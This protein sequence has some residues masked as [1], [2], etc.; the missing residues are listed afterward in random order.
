M[1]PMVSPV[2]VVTL[3]QTDLEKIEVL[4]RSTNNWSTWS[5]KIQ[6]Y[7]LLKHGGGY[8]LGLIQRPDPLID[9]IGAGTWDL[10]NLC[11]IAALRTR[12]TPEEGEFLRSFTN[13]HLAWTELKGR[14]EKVGPI[15][16]ILLIQQALSTRFRRGECLSVTSTMLTELVR[17]IYAISLPK[18]EDFLMIML[19]NAMTD[20]FPHVRN[21]IADAITT[22]SPSAPY[23]PSNIRAR[24]DVE[25][26]LI[27]SD[28]SKS[29]DVAMVANNK[30]GHTR[31]SKT[32]SDCGHT[33]HSS[34]CTTCHG[35]GHNAKDCFGKGGAMEG[36][37]D[38]VL[39]RKRAAR[40]ATT[41]GG[42]SSKMPKPAS[43]GKPGGLRYDTSGRAYLLDSET[44][45]AVYVASTGSTTAA[46]ASETTQ[47]FAG[48]ASDA[49][50]PSFIRELSS[51]HDDEFTALLAAFDDIQ[52]SLDW[53]Q[54]SRSVDFAGLTYKAPN[55][56]QRTIVDP[57]IVP[58][59]LD[60]GASVHI[61]NTEGDFF[62]L[63]P[64]S[65]RTVNGV[66]SSSMQAMG[67]GTLRLVVAKGIH[68]TLDN[69][70]FIPTATVRLISV[71]S[72]CAAHRCVASFDAT[73]CWVQASSGTRMLSGTLTSRHLYALSGG[74]LSAEHA[75]LMQRLPTLQS[76]HRRL[77]HANYRS[78]YDLARSGNATG[79][80][81]NLS[82]EPPICDDCILGKQT[83]TSVPKVCVGDKATRKLGIVHVDLM[84]HP[85]TVSAAGNKYIMDIIDDFSSY[86]WAL[87]LTSKAEAPLALQAWERAREL[88]VGTK[89]GIY[90]SDNGELKS[91]AMHE[92][93]LSRGTQHQFTAPY[94]SAQNGRVE[95]LHRTLM[96][97]ARAM[98]SA[99]NAPVNRWDEFVLTACYLTN[100]TPVASQA[101]H[102]PYE[103]WFG[104]KPNL[105]H[106]REIG[107]RAFV[108]IQSQ[109]N[110]KVYN[111]SLEC[112]LIGYSPDSKAYRCYHRASHKV[113]V[114]YH[115]SFIESHDAH[116]T[117]F[118]PG[119]TLNDT[120]HPESTSISASIPPLDPV[121]P[122]VSPPV[123]PLT[124]RR[125]SRVPVPSEKRCAMEG[126]TYVTA[127]QR[128]IQADTIAA[129]HLQALPNIPSP[130]DALAAS[131][132]EDDLAHLA[133]LFTA[134]P[135]HLENELSDDPSTY[136]EAMSSPHATEWTAALQEEFASLKDLGV[137]KLVPRSS[138]PPGRKIMRGRPV[139]KLKRD[140]D[141]NPARFKARYVCKG[142]SAVW[143][144]DYTKTSAPTT[145]L[146]SFRVLAHLG[147]ALDWEINQID[148]KTAFLH[149]LL[150]TDEVCYMEQP[151]GFVE[152]GKA[153][154]V[155]ELQKALYGMKQGGLV[156]NRT[157]NQAMISWGF[158]RLKCEHCIYYR[159]TDAGILLV[160]IHVDDFFT[161]GSSK[162]II[163]SFKDQLHTKW[164]ISDLGEA[165]FCVGIAIERDRTTRTIRLSQHALIDRIVLQFGLKDAT[166]ISTPMEPGLHLSRHH[167]APSSAAERDL[168]TWTPYRSLVGSLMYIAI[169]TRPDIA[170]AVQQ[171]CKFLD[172]YGTAHWEAAKRV[173]R[174]LKGTRD[175][176]LTLGGD[177]TARLLRYTDSDLAGCPDTRRSISGYCCTLGGGIV[178]W[179]ARQQ[180]TVSLSTCKAE[181][182]AA[183]EAASEITWLR[184]LLLEIDFSQ[185]SA[186]PLLCD[187]NGSIILTEDS[188]FH[189]RVKQI[190]IKYHSIRQKVELGQLKLHYV[191][192]KDNLADIFT[193]PLPRKDF[194][195]L[196]AYLGLH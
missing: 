112:V 78:V 83:R 18:E 48:L 122:P 65:P 144:Q 38:E 99:C 104:H 33:G 170:F 70:L 54:H 21:H 141:G 174:Y 153:D 53:R 108:L 126:K 107:C 116:E 47:E 134:M 182:I 3:S 136:S 115:V 74:Q 93:L 56:R 123:E 156:W 147:A 171:L 63:R 189:A 29:G 34:C 30:G 110:P 75:Y 50:T 157:L 113:I 133:N 106:L 79:M 46:A 41:K 25:Q 143:G 14:H 120:N 13:A 162:H 138:V 179:S 155:W 81:I 15:A 192:S 92:W 185:L 161:V 17:R 167:H 71:S 1:P 49:I 173:V 85:D 52:T 96:G 109:H 178:T 101:G 177:Y 154:H 158:S 64:I 196:R 117:P 142:Y 4:D 61:S 181:Y 139:F 36:K 68:I 127:A 45:E 77:G 150:A 82:T 9:P 183:S 27:D 39:A 195:R 137:Y 66:G 43:T 8:L 175:L 102:T 140:Q 135:D 180:K 124:T 10:N 187:N 146:E 11:I 86:A 193:K 160:A 84:E 97:K 191:Q 31:S 105:S 130:P 164:A 59:F 169:G 166:P 80:P 57:A 6:N 19:L 190:D 2:T 32:C 119:V 20:D 37:K 103:R 76:W 67:I 73:S 91:T 118:W 95:R 58:F 24:L 121:N 35:W 194:E 87:P 16:Q 62:N 42:S 44:Q 72:L 172:C 100:R 159:R 111:R 151:E 89:V 22:S 23:G 176:T 129:E 125:S 165:K 7:L 69:I 98:R 88:E 5:D 12:S 168:M 94:T 149:G 51:T 55:Q 90:R 152:P 114:S 60:S 186:T 26:Q 184:S 28:K 145:R 128:A 163:S 188:S 148:V 132:S 131:L 40:D